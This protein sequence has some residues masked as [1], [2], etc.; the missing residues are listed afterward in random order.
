MS[1]SSDLSAITELVSSDHLADR[2][3][4]CID[5]NHPVVLFQIKI[6]QAP[7]VVRLLQSSH[8]RAEEQLIQAGHEIPSDKIILEVTENIANADTN[9]AIETMNKFK[10]AGYRLALDDIGVGSSNFKSLFDF[11][12]DYFKI[13]RSYCESMRDNEAVRA[14]IQIII[15]EA[16]KT[17]KKAIAEGI[18]DE[19][20]LELLKSMGVN[21][22]QRFITG[23]P[24]PLIPAPRT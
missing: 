8:L 5:N 9:A 18:P 16:N 4:A 6:N 22:S 20:T 2:M 17:H 23:T 10:S 7:K 21:Y 24:Q 14:F 12:V 15:N 11:P 1:S 13:D 19:E 3:Q